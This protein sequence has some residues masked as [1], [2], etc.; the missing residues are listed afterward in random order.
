MLAAHGVGRG[1]RIGLILPNSPQYVIAYYA[2]LRLGAVIT[3]NNPLYTARELAHQIQDAG[4]KVVLCLDLLYPL[5][6]GVRE[7]AGN[8]TVIVT[9]I[10]EQMPTLLGMLAPVKFKK[11]AKHK[12]EPWPPVPADAQVL[13]WRDLERKT[14]PASAPVEVD[15]AVDPAVLIYTGG[16]TGPS[17]G[18]V[19]THRNIEANA[20]QGH[21]WFPGITEGHEGMLCVLP[22]FH[23]FGMLAMNVGIHMGAQ[24][25]LLPRFDLTLVLK[26]IAKEKPSLF[27]GVPRIYIA[28]NESPLTRKYDIKSIKACVSGA[29]PLPVAVAKKFEEITGGAQV[30]EGYGMT[31]CSPVT[32]ANPFLGERRPGAIGLPLPDT[33]CKIVDLENPEREVAQ[34]ESGELCIRG[35]QVMQSYWNKPEET[36]NMIRNGWLHTGDVA[37]MDPDGYFR[38]VDRLKDMVLV[39]GFNVY[40]TEIEEVLYRNPKI[41]K[42]CVIGVPDDETGEALKAFVVLREGESATPEELVTWIRNPDTG[43]TGYRVP[44]QIEIRTELPETMIGKVLRRV[45]QE[46]EKQK[47]TA[48]AG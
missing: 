29:A 14:G 42:C 38:I 34:G 28:M 3:G 32:H 30:V 46:E 43:L 18:A 37:T 24:L 13:W 4:C 22:F 9:K 23:A 44:K 45:L 1:D 39:S 19:L 15:A 7:D 8:P 26:A 33:E 47:R 36:A 6:A 25:T 11:E 20:A 31:E 48:A 5:F 21:A 10:T 16:T 27:P 41:E 35:P 2:A 17:K 40:P 12:G